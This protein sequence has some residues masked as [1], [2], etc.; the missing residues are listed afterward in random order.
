MRTGST[1]GD[2]REGNLILNF[3]LFRDYNDGGKHGSGEERGVRAM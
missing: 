3:F 2:A 1:Q